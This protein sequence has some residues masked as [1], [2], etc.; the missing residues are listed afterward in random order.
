MEDKE[1]T[2][3]SKTSEGKLTAVL[4]S[5]G[6]ISMIVDLL[7]AVGVIPTTDRDTIIALIVSLILGVNSA[8]TLAVY[9]YQRTQLKKHALSLKYGK[10]G[11]GEVLG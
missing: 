1:I 7:I 9:I 8:I 3:G 2:L 4:V 6:V 11:N 5:S 10:V